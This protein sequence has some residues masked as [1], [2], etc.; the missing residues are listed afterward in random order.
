VLL[1]SPAAVL[2]IMVGV[3][4]ESKRKPVLCHEG[5]AA[6]QQPSSAAGARGG[7]AEETR[8]RP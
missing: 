6:G 5:R 4:Q 2:E 1:P 8:A 7:G 3:A